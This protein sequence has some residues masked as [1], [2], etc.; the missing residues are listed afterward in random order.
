MFQKAHKKL[1]TL[2]TILIASILTIVTLIYLIVSEK[3]LR[4]SNEVSFQND[5]E[6]IVSNIEMQNILTRQW[7]RTIEFNGKY[8]VFLTDNNIPLWIN[9]PS[10]NEKRE[11]LFQEMIKEYSRLYPISDK[12]SVTVSYPVTFSFSVPSGSSLLSLKEPYYAYFNIIEHEKSNVTLSVIYPLYEIKQQINRQR[13]QF[14][15]IDLITI[16]FLSRLASVLIK[17][18]LQPIEDNH[19][20]QIRFVA[21]ASHEL[22]TPLAV[23]LSSIEAI[24]HAPDEEKNGFITPIESEVKR[25]SLLINDMLTLAKADNHTWNIEFK[26]VQ[27]DTLI[28][29]ICEAFELLARKKNIRLNIIL[30]E[31]AMPDCQ[32]DEQRITQVITILLHNAISYSPCDSKIFISLSVMD[33]YFLI[34]IEDHGPGIPDEEKEKVFERFYRIDK[35]RNDK[36]H[37]GLGLC[38]AAE[39]IHSH[40]STIT[41]KDTP[42]GGS[43]FEFLLEI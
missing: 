20:E 17:R 27:L 24:R 31:E 18:I 32:C 12:E 2:C 3:N 8:I 11:N 1:S 35:S 25:M 41:I 21:A 5:M 13:F 6:I 9:N 7:Y 23:I 29:N 34:Q 10:N 40:N 4:E 22:R 38:I 37:F 28:L 39:I 14:I 36:E 33:K 15:I 16:Y 42:G 30:P 43:T 19:Q 26:P